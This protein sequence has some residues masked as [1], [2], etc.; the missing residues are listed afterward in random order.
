MCI[1]FVL[2]WHHSGTHL[3]QQLKTRT[4]A[5]IL[6]HDLSFCRTPKAQKGLSQRMQACCSWLLYSYLMHKIPGDVSGNLP[7]DTAKSHEPSCSHD[8]RCGTKPE[9]CEPLIASHTATSLV[10]PYR[11]TGASHF[12]KGPSTELSYTLQN[13]NLHN[14]YPKTEYLII[15]SFGPFRVFHAGA[16]VGPEKHKNVTIRRNLT[17]RVGNGGYTAV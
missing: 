3:E 13:T 5:E 17:R 16:D 14:Y 15:G 6:M 2:P 11:H 7:F 10:Q 9:K 4:L 1:S 8:F 12:P